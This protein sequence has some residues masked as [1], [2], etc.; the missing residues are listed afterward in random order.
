MTVWLIAVAGTLGTTLPLQIRPSAVRWRRQQ[1]ERAHGRRGH[2]LSR[3]VRAD[4]A[5]RRRHRLDVAAGTVGG[6][7]DRRL[8]HRTGGHTLP[9]VVIGAAVGLAGVLG[10]LVL[11]GPPPRRVW[12]SRLLG[13]A[14]STVMLLHGDHLRAEE[15]IRAH[16]K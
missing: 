16:L 1:S 9:E 10:V 2:S 13:S 7:V 15:Q 8:A 12:P 14:L 6:P 3:P 11:A 5:A 4:R